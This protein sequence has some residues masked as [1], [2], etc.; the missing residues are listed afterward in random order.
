MDKLVG[1]T[2]RVGILSLA[3]LGKYHREFMAITTFL[4]TKNH[5]LPAEQSRMFAHGFPPELWNRVAHHLQ[6]KLTDHFLTTLILWKK[7]MTPRIS[8]FMA[9]LI[10]Q[11]HD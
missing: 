6:L 4:I 11:G 9:P 1:E 7:S 5:I 10:C 3:D 8:S 2:S